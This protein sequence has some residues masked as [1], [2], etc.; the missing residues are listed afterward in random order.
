[1][2]MHACIGM[3]LT[4]F[5]MLAL[6]PVLSATAAPEVVVEVI[7]ENGLNEITKTPCDDFVASIK[8]TLPAGVVIDWWDM[9]IHWDPIV[10][11]LQTGTSA[12]VVE[13]D[14]MRPFGTTM[15]LCQ[16]PDNVAGVLPVIACAFLAGGDASGS[17]ILCD[18]KFHCKA[19][20]DGNIII[21]DPYPPGEESCLVALVGAEYKPVPIDVVING[22]VHQLSPPPTPPNAAFTPPDGAMVD[23]CTDVILDGTASTLGYDTLPSPGHVCPI[24]EWRWEIDEG[25]DGTIEHIFYGEVV[26]YHCEAPGDVGIKLTVWAPD[27][28]PPTHP[29]YVEYDSE[30]H[31]IHQIGWEIPVYVDIKPGSFPNP[32]NLKSQGLISVAICGTADFDV[33]TIDPQTIRLTREGV[34]DGVAPI[35]WSYEDVATPYTGEP[36]G[37]HELGGDGYLDLTLKF[38][39]QELVATLGL[40]AFKGE[41]IVLILTGNLKE[42]DGGTP[43]RGQDC[44]WILNVDCRDLMRI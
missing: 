17:G 11:E 19:P 43:I 34:E 2:K 14:F 35:R 4:L 18:I 38:K 20:G 6:L 42:E 3:L 31:I 33:A 41:V 16:E 40:D 28:L 13:G 7:F 5:L 36:C 12:D 8:V 26:V 32:L 9:E 21:F 25:C 15:F 29:D 23:V 24:T 10:L 1:M 44:V 39:T 30:T 22:V 27:P 37:G